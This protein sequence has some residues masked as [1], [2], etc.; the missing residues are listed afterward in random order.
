MTNIFLTGYEVKVDSEENN[1]VANPAN[2]VLHS[3]RFIAR[4]NISG[5]GSIVFHPE[6]L[7]PSFRINQLSVAPQFH[8]RVAVNTIRLPRIHE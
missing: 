8:E 6:N 1:D 3:C 4:Y 2:S 7:Q 5:R